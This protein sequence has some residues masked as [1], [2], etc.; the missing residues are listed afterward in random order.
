MR[1]FLAGGISSEQYEGLVSRV[2][3]NLNCQAVEIDPEQVLRFN[4]RS[5]RG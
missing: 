3:A 5:N 4:P 1:Q 2:R